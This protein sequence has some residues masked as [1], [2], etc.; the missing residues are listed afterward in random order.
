MLVLRVILVPQ[1]Y[2]IV[3][4]HFCK[5]DCS[6]QILCF[7]PM[8]IHYLNRRLQGNLCIIITFYHMNMHW[9]VLI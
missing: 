3:F 4:I 8:I 2:Y 6:F 1:L 5:L 9:S 7:Q